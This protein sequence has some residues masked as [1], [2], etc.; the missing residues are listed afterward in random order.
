MKLILA[1]T[2]SKDLVRLRA[3]IAT[4]DPVAASRIASDLRERIAYLKTFPDMGHAVP[5][6]PES[7]PLREFAFGDFVVRYLRLEASLVILR[8][9]HHREDRR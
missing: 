8:V 6:A 3:F 7:L 4:H 2:A 5:E 1:R 9:W